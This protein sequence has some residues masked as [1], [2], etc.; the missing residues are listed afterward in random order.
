MRSRFNI[1]WFENDLDY[2]NPRESKFDEIISSLK[3]LGFSPNI[4]FYFNSTIFDGKRFLERISAWTK[5]HFEIKIVN[6]Y[7]PTDLLEIDFNN[8]DLVMMDYNLDDAKGDEIIRHIRHAPNEFYTEI[9]FYSNHNPPPDF[10]PSRTDEDKIEAYLRHIAWRDWIYC[11]SRDWVFLKCWRVLS[12]IVKKSESLN[13]L[14]WLVMAETSEI[15]E[16]NRKILMKICDHH[17]SSIVIW[18]TPTQGVN[19]IKIGTYLLLKTYSVEQNY[20]DIIYDFDKTGSA[21]LYNW[22]LYFWRSRVLNTTWLCGSLNDYDRYLQETKRNILAHQPEEDTS[23]KTCMKIHDLSTWMPVEFR[24][25]DLKNIRIY[26]REY[27]KKLIEL[28]NALP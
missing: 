3:D 28:Y 16:M 19:A 14:R 4:I 2:I 22:V 26:I 25:Q 11:S 10:S 27:K 12:T 18:S 6:S 23:T 24:E 1:Y 21:R 13:N 15:D 7:N 20:Q 17:I 8:A 5:E 9:L